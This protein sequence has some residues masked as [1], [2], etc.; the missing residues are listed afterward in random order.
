MSEN[1]L[2][3]PKWTWFAIG[4]ITLSAIPLF[5]AFSHVLTGAAFLVAMFA[6]AV[7]YTVYVFVCSAR[8]KAD[9]LGPAMRRYRRRLAVALVSYFV[10]L[11][12]S[13]YLL[14]GVK[15]S[16]PLLWLVAAAPALPILGVLAVMGL[17]LKEEPDEFERAVHV[18]AM[19]WGLGVVLAVTTVWGFLSNA[20]V[21][22]APPLFLVFPLFCLAWGLSQPLIR[23]R[24][25]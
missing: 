21:V 17:Y 11:M 5:L 16:G 13:I 4:V 12:G 2:A 15:L 10:V 7:V 22:P 25:Q 1:A 24:Y 19:V 9:R 8:L 23:G 3:W 6:W 14:Q 20:S 18:E